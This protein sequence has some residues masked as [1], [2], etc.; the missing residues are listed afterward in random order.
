M[1]KSSL[2]C[3]AIV[4]TCTSHTPPPAAS[5]AAAAPIS[6][7]PPAFRLPESVR[8]KE[9]AAELTLRPGAERF[10]G[11]VEIDVELAASTKA[12]WLHAEHLE[13]REAQI[14][15]GDVRHAAKTVLAKPTWLGV[16][17]DAPIGPGPARLRIAYE[18]RINRDSGAGIFQG[19]VA[20]DSYI[21]TQF[22]SKF[23]RQAFPCFD[24]PGVKVPWRLTLHVPRGLVAAANTPIEREDDGAGGL[25]VVRFK[26][27]QR[28]PSYLVAFVVGP[29]DVIDGGTAGRNNTP[30]RFLV[31]K[32]RGGETAA[33]REVTQR[34][35]TWLEEYMDVAY[36]Y[37][38]LDTVAVAGSV[39]HGGAME[40]AGLITSNA[41]WVLA[42][43]R[44]DT[45][46]RRLY[47]VQT[48][49]VAH[50]WFGDLVTPRWWDDIWLNE[51][52]A[53]WIAAKAKGALEPNLVLVSD[54]IESQSGAM[55]LDLEPRARP[56]HRPVASDYDIDDALDGSIYLKG[57]SVLIM[58][59]TWLGEEAVRRGTHDHLVT[60]AHGNATTADFAASLAAAAGKDVSSVFRSYIEQAGVPAVSAALT[61]DHG[62]ARV[63]LSQRRMSPAPGSEL[64]TIPVCVRYGAAGRAGQRECFVLS[65]KQTERPLTGGCPAW[66]EWNEGHAGYYLVEHTPAS[67]E[68]AMRH[69]D[70]L[71]RGEL[72]GT[73]A[74]AHVLVDA[75]TLPL[76][77]ILRITSPL[78]DGATPDV[79][80]WL[81]W[82]D[83]WASDYVPEALRPALLERIRQRHG[84]VARK[85]GI[86]PRVGED[87]MTTK[88]RRDLV[89]LVASTA[90]DAWFGPEAE[91][92]ARR[93][94]ADP[95]SLDVSDRAAISIAARHGGRALFD[96]YK[97]A[98]PA[99]SLSDQGTILSAMVKF[100]DPALVREAFTFALSDAVKPRNVT[101][102]FSL[103]QGPTR[104]LLWSLIEEHAAAIVARLP[105]DLGTRALGI[106]NYACTSDERVAFVRI[107]G[108]RAKSMKNGPEKYD[109][110]LTNIDRCIE[111][112]K[113][114]E[115]SVAEW[116][117]TR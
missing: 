109:E 39:F 114:Q 73:L 35:L 78:L 105:E 18:G 9:I 4:A 33:L 36:P 70:R 67:L 95:K 74:D 68:R 32:G 87:A 77:H 58:L 6:E 51:S 108:E 81:G 69:R 79:R 99:M 26:K 89:P 14:V 21:Q 5:P 101:R 48:H 55:Y 42:S 10:S 102:V 112:R 103:P 11:V 94:L 111:I 52:F 25:R 44:T 83:E 110:M 62:D 113:V 80:L 92:L 85:L 49:E 88:L 17:V 60:H 63:R 24:E 90:G 100:R 19:D 107:F 16:V 28:L 97:T 72:L 2:I 47:R 15:V 3:V 64:W 50:H 71:T 96:A 53:Q 117:R 20:G 86:G 82:F 104:A 65:E 34:S 29:Y 22:Q 106:G 40:N 7:T 57:E 75:A 23:A 93:W 116:L 66:V 30:L 13:P 8:A 59:E 98:A 37:E 1:R 91:R 84:A 43:Q 41:E 54:R 27:T 56:L 115:P 46:L 12:I 45:V 76:G 61:C 38:K 31:P